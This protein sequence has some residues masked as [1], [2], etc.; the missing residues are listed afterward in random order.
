MYRH[1]FIVFC[2]F[3][4][5][6]SADTIS[7]QTLNTYGPFYSENRKN[8]KNSISLFLKNESCDINFF[9]EVWLE[10]DYQKLK[11]ASQ[12]IDLN[13]VHHD[14]S[15]NYKKRSGL[16]TLAKGDILKKEFYIFPL[17]D[18]WIG[19]IYNLLNINKG[20]GVVYTNLSKA[21]NTPLIAV[22]V[23]LHHLSQKA[24]LLQL[25]YYLKWF[26]NQSVLKHP[27]IFAGDF[28]FEPHSLEFE[29]IKYIFRFK[30]PQSLLNLPYHCTMCPENNAFISY[31]L[32]QLFLMGY[33][34]TVD[35]IFFRSSPTI[36]LTPKS[37]S[38]FP[39]KYN[40]VFLSDH[41]G[42]KAEIEFKS[43]L[44]LQP[45]IRSELEERKA[46]F[47][48]TIDKTLSQLENKITLRNDIPLSQYYQRKTDE[49]MAINFLNSLRQSL[50]AD[51]PLLIQ[52]L[53]QN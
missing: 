37:F 29:I 42:V 45:I 52:H 7:V 32:S 41:Y 12:S 21:P 22:N 8:R 31:N 38:V 44:N 46:L 14:F 4:S 13:S 48:A 2:L 35:Y 36:R 3:I 19:R 39:K 40:G 6:T 53:S 9:Q 43:F 24:R 17:G 30:E 11:Q 26:L 23:H 34:K 50:K 51:E 18:D 25:I 16:M 28:N 10:E 5:S 20:F 47:L 1:L 49:V 33:E 15:L 27:V